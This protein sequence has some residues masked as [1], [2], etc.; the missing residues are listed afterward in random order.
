MAKLNDQRYGYGSGVLKKKYNHN[1]FLNYL[2]T[3]KKIKSIEIS[4]RYKNSIKSSL[5]LK[6]KNIHYKIDRIVKDKNI[7]K[8]ELT[9]EIDKYIKL[10]KK[11][12]DILYLHQN[13]LSII[14]DKNILKILEEI[15]ISKKI[16]YI[17]VS[18]YNL[19]ELNFALKSKIINVIQLPVN[20]ADS[21]LYSKI[22][23]NSNK[24]FIARSIYMQGTLINNLNTH[25][26][27][28][29][30]QKYIKIVKNICNKYNLNYFETITSYPFNLKKINH[31]IISSIYKNNIKKILGSIKSIDKKKMKIL[32]QSSR[33]YKSWKNPRNW[34]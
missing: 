13:E 10:T 31:V 14:S 8:K 27:K 12:I 6:S 30:I 20:V 4:K 21:Y 15:K 11:K 1:N 3:Q 16:K 5:K 28:N 33:E 34:K 26:K 19:K 32:Y 17:G 9:K 18:I 29:Q 7:I 25:P 23:S 2:N 22:P 24:I